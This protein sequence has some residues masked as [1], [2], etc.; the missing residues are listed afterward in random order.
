VTDV[1]LQGARWRAHQQTHRRGD[2]IARM[3]SSARLFAVGWIAVF[4]A[5]CHGSALIPPAFDA[6]GDTGALRDAGKVDAN[7]GIGGIG[8]IGGGGAGGSTRDAAGDSAASA[9]AGNVCPHVVRASD[10]PSAYATDCRPTWAAVLANPVCTRSAGG[11]YSSHESRAD[12][13]GYHIS[14]VGQLDSSTTYYYDAT[15]GGLVAIYDDAN[16]RLFCVAGPPS[17]VKTD[18][19]D[20]TLMSV[21]P[22]DGG[23]DARR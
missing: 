17:G 3:A 15:S 7:G 9:D 6:G 16:G 23:S 13:D 10:C 2:N 12:C 8:G 11:F 5:G 18:C 20:V 14:V 21:C 4:G 22:S 1:T 19:P